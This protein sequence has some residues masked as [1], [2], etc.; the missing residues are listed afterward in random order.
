MD[1]ERKLRDENWSPLSGIGLRT[2]ES[3]LDLTPVNLNNIYLKDNKMNKPKKMKPIV[4]MGTKIKYTPE[5][6]E[7]FQEMNDKE[8]FTTEPVGQ[9]YVDYLLGDIG[10][11]STSGCDMTQ[12]FDEL[13]DDSDWYMD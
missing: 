9:D 13:S 11:N 3:H 12:E 1:R 2:T 10:M 6:L 5:V 7:Y 4:F 8:E